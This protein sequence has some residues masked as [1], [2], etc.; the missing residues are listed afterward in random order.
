VTITEI[1]ANSLFGILADAHA[2]AGQHPAMTA[3]A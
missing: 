3:G 2:A 1:G